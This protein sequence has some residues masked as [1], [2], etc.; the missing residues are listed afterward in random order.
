MTTPS[1]PP[2]KV[3]RPLILALVGVVAIAIGIGIYDREFVGE[4]FFGVAPPPPPP[5]VPTP[6]LAASA[7][8]PHNF[9]ESLMLEW[10]VLK[11][12]EYDDMAAVE[13]RTPLYF[14]HNTN[15]LR[16]QLNNYLQVEGVDPSRSYKGMR[17]VE[18]GPGPSLSV[19]V[20]AAMAGAEHYD[21]LEVA[22]YGFVH[23]PLPYDVMLN[24]AISDPFFYQ[25]PIDSVIVERSAKGIRF[26]PDRISFNPNCPAEHLGLADKGCPIAPESAHVVVSLSVLEH[27]ADLPGAIERMKSV[28]V[29]GGIAVHNAVFMDHDTIM[30]PPTG[31]PIKI[32]DH[33]KVSDEAW[34]RGVT[35]GGQ[36]CKYK[37]ANQLRPIDVKRLFEKAGFEVVYYTTKPD[38]QYE[39][40]RVK[41]AEA[42]NGGW[43]PLSDEDWKEIDPHVKSGH[44]RAEVEEFL[45]WIVAR[46][47]VGK[48]PRR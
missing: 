17:F 20:L 34:R 2:T 4:K 39:A 15:W 42:L 26:N 14:I 7:C 31:S 38:T 5:T 21:G 48:A 35:C 23:D 47:P 30:R 27:I 1:A 45:V 11:R 32:Y 10:A 37:L 25:Q 9:R 41:R 22:D 6:A 36:H 28:L 33:L 18:L 16:R 19:G 3:R 12:W 43:L 13:T 44:T 46:K 29:P 8:F 24:I 40:A